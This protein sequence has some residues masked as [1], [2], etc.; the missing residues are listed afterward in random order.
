MPAIRCGW[1]TPC[2]TPAPPADWHI[3]QAAS[4]ASS[5]LK[6]PV[7][8]RAASRPWD[9]NVRGL[10]RRGATMSWGTRVRTGLDCL[11]AQDFAPLRGLR[12]GLV[13]HPAAVDHRL[14]H[15]CELLAQAPDVRLAALFGPE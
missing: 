11:C 4:R 2:V 14:R 7:R 9:H 1:P 5:T 6:R 10:V 15:A 3:W 12:V 13:T 8:W